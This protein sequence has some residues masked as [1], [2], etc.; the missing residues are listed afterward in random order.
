MSQKVIIV[1]GA[2]SGIGLATVN[3]L[4]ADGHLVVALARRKERLQSLA[5]QWLDKVLTIAGDVTN[6]EDVE[7]LVIRTLDRFG[8]IDVLINNAGVGML[9]PMESARLQDWHTMMDVNVKGVLSC[10]YGCLPYLLKSTGHIVNLASVAAHDVF[11]NAVVYCASKHAINAITVGFR[12]EFRDRVKITNISPGAVQ[13]EFASHTHD[14]NFKETFEKNFDGIVIKPEDIADAVSHILH[15][16]NHLVV[17]EYIVR[18]N[19]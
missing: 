11:P 9:G 4:I 17:N 3:R 16:P 5:D 12:K 14:E 13:T 7:R 15:L 2:S 10:I 19:K 8:R 18:P 1:T 6:I